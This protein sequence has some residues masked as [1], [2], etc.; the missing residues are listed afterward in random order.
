MADL[1]TPY[2]PTPIYFE[3]SDALEYIGLDIPIITRRMDANWSLLLNMTNRLPIGFRL[4]APMRAF[5]DIAGVRSRVEAV[6]AA[7]EA[8]ASEPEILA[9]RPF[10]AAQ[11]SDAAARIRRALEE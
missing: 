2:V 9:D 8:E 5:T 7:I 10:C 3:D 11:L 4:E 6:C 1:T